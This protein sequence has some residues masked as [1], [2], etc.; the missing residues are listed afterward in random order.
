MPHRVSTPNHPA[1]ESEIDLLQRASKT[2]GVHKPQGCNDAACL[3]AA[4]H[5]I[6]KMSECGPRTGPDAART[7]N[8][9]HT[10]CDRAPNRV[11][12]DIYRF[13]KLHRRSRAARLI[14]SEDTNLMAA[15]PGVPRELNNGRGPPLPGQAR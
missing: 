3:R 11:P 10:R 1:P 5:R 6:W 13:R 9:E 8:P 7:V 14:G 12:L 15:L 2:I 4:S